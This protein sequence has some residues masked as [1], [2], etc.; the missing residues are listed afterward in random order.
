[1]SCRIELDRRNFRFDDRNRSISYTLYLS[2][3]L[4]GEPT[5]I[6]YRT[7]FLDKKEYFIRK[8]KGE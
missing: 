3:R 5:V 6:R 7:Q 8:L 4:Q 1:M 2:G